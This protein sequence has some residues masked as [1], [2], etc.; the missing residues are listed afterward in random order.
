MNTSGT[1]KSVKVVLD[2]NRSNRFKIYEPFMN[3][4]TQNS[5]RKIAVKPGRVAIAVE[6]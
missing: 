2:G 3:P 5:S 4:I 6:V 1:V